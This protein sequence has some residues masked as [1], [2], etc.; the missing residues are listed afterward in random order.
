MYASCFSHLLMYTL[1]FFTSI[2]SKGI[3]SAK[4]LAFS[5]F[6]K[7]SFVTSELPAIFQPSALYLCPVGAILLWI[8]LLLIR[9]HFEHLSYSVYLPSVVHPAAVR[10]NPHIVSMIDFLFSLVFHISFNPYGKPVSRYCHDHKGHCLKNS[11]PIHSH[12]FR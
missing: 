10:P 2:F 11:Y 1:S 6:S 12:I 8:T 3:F 9:P 4:S 7:S 5:A